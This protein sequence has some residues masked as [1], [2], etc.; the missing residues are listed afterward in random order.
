MNKTQENQLVR[1]IFAKRK[2][3]YFCATKRHEIEI[4]TAKDNP[5][6]PV[7]GAVMTYGRYFK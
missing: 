6:C 2:H 4:R 7:C 1:D 3:N 5:K